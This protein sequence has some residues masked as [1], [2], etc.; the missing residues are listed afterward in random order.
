MKLIYFFLFLMFLNACNATTGS[1]QRRFNDGSD[2]ALTQVDL[3]R[4]RPQRSTNDPV[5]QL[6]SILRNAPPTAVGVEMYTQAQVSDPNIRTTI[7]RVHVVGPW[8]GVCI[9]A[10]SRVHID[11][12]MNQ[13]IR[14]LSNDRYTQ[15]ET[16]GVNAINDISILQSD[17]NLLRAT[18]QAR[19][20]SRDIALREAD[21]TIETLRRS[22]TNN[23]WFVVGLTVGGIALAS[24]TTAAIILLS[25]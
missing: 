2:V 23:V 16:L 8:S 21:A 5:L 1:N 11:T 10:E 13:A 4:Y 22:P 20:N 12:S 7:P 18:Y 15:L 14:T 24:G 3:R 25:R 6:G 9:N 19:V 17:F